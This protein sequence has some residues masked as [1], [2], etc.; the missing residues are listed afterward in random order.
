MPP[1]AEGPSLAQLRD[2]SLSVHIHHGAL[3]SREEQPVVRIHLEPRERTED[4]HL[5]LERLQ[6][7][8]APASPG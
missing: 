3:S 7:A 4:R 8:S 2:G 1:C 6:R 5:A